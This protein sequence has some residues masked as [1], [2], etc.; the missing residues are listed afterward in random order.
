MRS[1]ALIEVRRA[2]GPRRPQTAPWIDRH[3]AR[4]PRRLP[5]PRRGDAAARRRWRIALRGALRRILGLA[6]FGRVP[7]PRPVVL[8]STRHAGYRRERIAYQTLPGNWVSAWL[9]VPDRRAGAARRP[10]VLCAHGHFPGGKRGVVDPRCAP[11]VAYGH[12]FAR[13]GCVVLAPDNA[14]MGERDVAL[15]ERMSDDGSITGCFLAWAR[16]NHVGLDLTGLRVFELMAGVSLLAAR[17]DVDPRAIGAA[18]LSGG[19]WLSQLLAALDERVAGA[20]LSGFFTTFAQT[21]WHGHCVCHHPRG[22]GAICELPDIAALIAPRPLFVESGRSDARYPLEPAFGRV[23]SAYRASG[24][25][26][27]LALDHYDGGHVFRG[28]ASIPWLV[29]RLRGRGR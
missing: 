11:G 12:E 7:L 21:V 23:A 26:Q 10:A 25:A 2:S 28:H 9:L 6:A 24:A 16:L 27:A 14:G 17:D 8:A 5:F 20:V 13:R 29:E 3:Y 1:A 18:G 22:I 15:A 19:C 4:V